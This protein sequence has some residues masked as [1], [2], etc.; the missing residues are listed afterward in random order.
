MKLLP[1]TV[2]RFLSNRFPLPYHLVVNLGARGNDRVHWDQRLAETWNDDGLSWPTKV[3]LIA[4]VA[5]KEARILDVACGNGSI[6]RALR[7]SGYQD[8]HAIELSDYAVARLNEE[9]LQ[10][11]RGVLPAIEH[12]DQHF[13][14]VI[15]SQVLEHII[16]RHA[17]AREVRR[18]L[19]PGG[20]AF[21]FVPDNCLGPIDEPEHVMVYD[22]AKLHAF[23]SKHFASVEVASMRDANHEMPVL[24]ARV[25]PWPSLT[26]GGSEAR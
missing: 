20:I 4:A 12:P 9:G 16:R 25:R 22:A 10:A 17:F 23:L 26:V 1:W 21:F 7:A 19:R 24:C 2:R 8:L 13:D 11:K 3:A 14:V 15:A 6:L 5:P 18:V